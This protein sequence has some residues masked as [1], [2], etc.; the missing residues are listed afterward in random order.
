[1]TDLPPDLQPRRR[2]EDRLIGLGDERR[3][4]QDKTKGTV[5]AMIDLVPEAQQAGISFD[6]IAK[7]IGVPRQTLYR[8]QEIAEFRRRTAK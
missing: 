3:E 4:L 2:I 7:L 1:M 5:K 8:W 6:G